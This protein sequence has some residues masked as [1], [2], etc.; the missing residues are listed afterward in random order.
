MLDPRA[1]AGATSVIVLGAGIAGLYAAHRLSESGLHVTV[2]D[3]VD[4][5]GGAHRSCH[6]GGFTFDLGSFFYEDGARIFELAPQIREQCPK[7]LRVQRRIAPTGS[8]LH[9][10]LEPREIL[11]QSSWRLPFALLDLA[12]SRLGV[13]RDGTLDAISRQRLGRT[14]FRTTGLEAYMRRFHHLPPREIDEGFFFHRMAHVERSTR[15]KALLHTAFRSLSPRTANAI[16]RPLHVRPRGGFEQI[17]TPIVANLK[18]RGVEFRFLERLECIRPQGAAFHVR[19]TMG[20]Y[21]A[22]VLVSTVPLESLHQALFGESSD[23]ISLDMTTLFVS[24]DWLDPRA[25]NVLF[26]FHGEGH[27]KRATVYS[28]IYPQPSGDREFFTVEA[29]IPRGAPHDPESIFDDFRSHA[30]ALGFA[31]GIR[32]EGHA[33]VRDCYPLYPPG[34]AARLR[35]VTERVSAAGVVLAGRQ[36]RFEYL[37]T[38][39]GVIRRVEEELDTAG[40]LAPAPEFAA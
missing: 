24:A 28:R 33:R 11:Q 9:Y 3:Q 8:I 23:L 15:A 1:S 7:V 16:R 35:T 10:P 22:D 36:G 21:I 37:P 2:I 5:A 20:S 34:S 32:L 27:W 13:R 18:A 6:I 26:N 29:T 25:G 38:S 39:S 40:I 30:S 31:R 12:G 14:F 19:T 17:F 4:R